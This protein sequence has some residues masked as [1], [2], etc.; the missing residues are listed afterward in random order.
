MRRAAGKAGA[1]QWNL[2]GTTT[3]RMRNMACEHAVEGA[4]KAPEQFDEN[5]LSEVKHVIAVLSGKK[6]ASASPSSP[7]RSPSS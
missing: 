5:N 3:E 1:L 4:P 7:P 2:F 6:A